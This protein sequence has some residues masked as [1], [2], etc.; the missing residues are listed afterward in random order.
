MR[1]YLVV[2]CCICAAGSSL[3]AQTPGEI[4]SELDWSFGA[5]SHTNGTVSVFVTIDDLTL[6]KRYTVYAGIDANGT[7]LYRETFLAAAPT[8]QVRV[9]FTASDGVIIFGS[10][11]NDRRI[12]FWRNLL[13]TPEEYHRY[14]QVSPDNQSDDVFVRGNTDNT[15]LFLYHFNGE[16]VQ[17][18]V[19]G[20]R[21]LVPETAFA[22][23][24]PESWT[25]F[26][27]CV[28]LTTAE[29]IADPQGDL[30]FEMQRR[31]TSLACMGNSLE[32]Q[33]GPCADEPVGAFLALQGPTPD[34]VV[35]EFR[36]GSVDPAEDTV[37]LT[38][39]GNEAAVI[40][41]FDPETHDQFAWSADLMTLEPGET[42]EITITPTAG[43]PWWRFIIPAPIAPQDVAVNVIGAVSNQTLGPTFT[44]SST[45]SPAITRIRWI[46]AIL[47]GAALTWGFRRRR[48]PG[49]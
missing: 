39:I 42:T 24:S 23:E 16:G 33:C 49:R 44:V 28:P 4:D 20:A 11:G 45:D 48:G 38:N 40:E 12:R 5:G 27:N 21:I 17:S 36:L 47:F 43:L 30:C 15:A 2:I 37:T 46:F 1:N 35:F 22:C 13:T 7:Q 6:N 25:F 14:D 29:I 26:D 41:G 10:R 19:D 8:T 34:E 18:T 3:L 32:F 9:A 31:Q